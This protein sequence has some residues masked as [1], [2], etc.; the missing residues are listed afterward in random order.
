MQTAARS[1]GRPRSS[2]LPDAAAL[3]NSSSRQ[4]ALPSQPRLLSPFAS[5][6]VTELANVDNRSAANEQPKRPMSLSG[7][8]EAQRQAKVPKFGDLP[9]A[10]SSLAA[11]LV[12]PQLRGR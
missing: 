1:Q 11:T 5:N 10:R 7:D 9:V 3:F 6:A 8:G 4:Q 12:P 2:P